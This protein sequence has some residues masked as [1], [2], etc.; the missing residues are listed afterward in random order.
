MR[1]RFLFKRCETC[2]SCLKN[3]EKVSVEDK[4]KAFN[5]LT[6][7]LKLGQAKI[8]KGKIIGWQGGKAGIS[9]SCAM[10]F[11]S[12]SKDALIRRLLALDTNRQTISIS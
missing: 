9:D 5:N 11:L 4:E 12:T 3:P 7:Q 1:S 10:A 8:I 6:K 2:P